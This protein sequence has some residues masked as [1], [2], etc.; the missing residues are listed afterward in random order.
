[1]S[2]RS[3]VVLNIKA[4]DALALSDDQVIERWLKLYRGSELVQRYNNGEQLTNSEQKQ[5]KATVEQYRDNLTNIS[6]FM[7]N[8]NEIIAR[9]ANKEDGCKGFS[10]RADSRCKLCLICLPYCK[11]C[12]TMT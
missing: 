3:Y 5:L 6:R 11:P 7:A 10:G 8:L 2:N 9:K 4:D 12:T 1:M